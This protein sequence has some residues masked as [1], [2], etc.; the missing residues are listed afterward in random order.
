MSKIIKLDKNLANQIA[1]WEVVERP[2]SVVKELVENS[3]DAWAS[4]IKVEITWGWI[5]EI[6]VI[7]NW[8]WID[9]DDLILVPEKYTTSKIKNLED[10]YNIMT[11]GFRWEAVASIS[12]VSSFKII[13]KT[14]NSRFWYALESNNGSWEYTIKESPSDDGT[15]I[16]V[17]DLFFNTPARLNYLKKERT[18]YSHILEFLNQV[19]LSYPNI[20]FEF[21]S[22]S[23]KVFKYRSWEKLKDRIYNIYWDDFSNNLISVD[24]ETTWI[25]I[26]GFISDPKVSFTNKNRQSLFVNKRI[27][28]SP[29]IYKAIS[30]AYNR[31][32]P[33]NEFPAYVL[34][35]EV[36]PTQVDVNV[37]PRKLEIRFADES[38][39]F[40]SVYNAIEQKLTWVSLID[41]T[42]PQS[43]PI[44]EREQVHFISS[45]PLGE[46][47]RGW[48]F[49]NSQKNYYTGSWTKFKSY[50]PYKDTSPNPSQ[51]KVSDAIDFS[52]QLLS[53][54][55]S[56]D[57]EKSNDLHDTSL[58]KIVWQVFNSYIVVET[59]DS[60]KVLDQHALAER[61]IYE[62]LVAWKYKSKT[63]GLLIWES[64]NLTPKELDILKENKY[65]FSLMNFDFEI[66]S[67]SIV[68]LNWIPDFIKKEDLKNIFLWILADIWSENF[69]SSLTL[70]EVR[71]K[72]FAYTSCRSAI[73]FWNKLSLF[74]INKLLND[75]V[76]DYSSTCP[77]GRPV[78]FEIWLDE[79]KWKYER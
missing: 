59:K 40:R 31:F 57:F 30:N 68:V 5:K 2:I 32:I 51:M 16:I 56:N 33:H 19:S 21:V 45:S 17:K 49:E 71:N 7:D 12:S 43:S 41:Q 64:F 8:E 42:S 28:K 47:S 4:E 60:L 78:V 23:K 65:T 20:W 54:S 62:K 26:T 11:F 1:A 75:S 24:F 37:H 29:L 63:Q 10:L 61:I 44:E 74:E 13:S 46:V 72:I 79:L 15:K 36:D 6:I 27:I 70:E 25:K 50:S 39:V 67:G 52:K 3:V 77:H 73:K 35:I 66:M 69:K 22:D 58:W 53:S 55:F 14:K 18:E 48:G 34:N 9:K 38:S 76:L